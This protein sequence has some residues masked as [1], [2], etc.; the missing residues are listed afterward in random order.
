MNSS[1]KI[2]SDNAKSTTEH[3]DEFDAAVARADAARAKAVRAR[4]DAAEAQAKADRAEEELDRA[5]EKA[6]RK[7][8]ALRARI[9]AEKPDTEPSAAAPNSN[10][11]ECSTRSITRE[12][13]V[14]ALGM[15]G[16]DQVGER[17]AAGLMAERQ[18][19]KLGETWNDL[20]VREHDDDDF[21]DE[22]DELDD[23]DAD[24][25]FD[26]E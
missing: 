21:G 22:D 4:A 2:K 12:L 3:R 19:A 24:E 7:G 9:K 17:A 1:K 11:H 15:L 8:E 26:D 6:I 20:I 16:S 5:L 18:R 14:K 25:E 23:D 10:G 13:L